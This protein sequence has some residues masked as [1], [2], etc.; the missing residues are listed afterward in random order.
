MNT[1]GCA[2]TG[3]ATTAYAIA[4]GVS[5]GLAGYTTGFGSVALRSKGD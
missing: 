5:M 4:A 1:V 3:C 2:T